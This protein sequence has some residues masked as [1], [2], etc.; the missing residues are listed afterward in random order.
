MMC[1]VCPEKSP[2]S[3]EERAVALIHLTRPWRLC[4]A[5]HVLDHEIITPYE[6]CAG[7]HETHDKIRIVIAGT[8]PILR[9]EAACRMP[10]VPV[11]HGHEMIVGIDGQERAHI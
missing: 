1:R 5:A 3:E 11:H 6:P 4:A 7:A 10:Q 2:F 9:I 8:V